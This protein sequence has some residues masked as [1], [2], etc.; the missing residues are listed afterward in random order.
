M[1]FPRTRNHV[2]KDKKIRK[3]DMSIQ[4]PTLYVFR[5]LDIKL[6]SENCGSLIKRWS[7]LNYKE[8]LTCKLRNLPLSW[9]IIEKLK[10]RK[11]YK[12]THK[13]VTRDIPFLKPKGAFNDCLVS[14]FFVCC[15][16]LLQ[17]ATV[18]KIFYLV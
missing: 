1:C 14:T 9:R 13:F 3:K 11:L 7:D 10:K 12:Q 6:L 17:K 18:A 15:L 8:L 16:F 4:G 2:N 5:G